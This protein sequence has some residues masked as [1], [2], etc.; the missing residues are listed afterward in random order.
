MAAARSEAQFE[1]A[2]LR[3][4]TGVALQDGIRGAGMTTSPPAREP[5]Q[6]QRAIS[7]RIAQT[8]AKAYF[9]SQL[10]SSDNAAVGRVLL[11]EQRKRLNRWL[12]KRADPPMTEIEAIRHF[13]EAGLSS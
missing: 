8:M 2:N 1:L 13:V 5:T 4:C 6:Q 7:A 10:E 9:E 3:D 11:P 12:K